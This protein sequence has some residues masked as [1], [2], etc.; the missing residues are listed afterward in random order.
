MVLSLAALAGGKGG[1]SAGGIG[2]VS[3]EDVLWSACSG[4][5]SLEALGHITDSELA[6]RLRA[7]QVVRCPFAYRSCI[8]Q[9]IVKLCFIGAM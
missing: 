6:E 4:L 2:A 5:D 1:P 3:R 8:C 7:A 9:K